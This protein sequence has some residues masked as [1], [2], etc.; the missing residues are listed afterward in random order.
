MYPSLNNDEL[1]YAYDCVGLVMSD[2]P[3]R[4]SSH[5]VSR[6]A[7]VLS[8]RRPGPK[9][10]LSSM[11]A[12]LFRRDAASSLALTQVTE[13]VGDSQ[14]VD[15][16]DT[17][18]GNQNFAAVVVYH[19]LGC[20]AN[21]PQLIT[22]RVVNL[23]VD[24]IAHGD[25]Y[26]RFYAS[27]ALC[28]MLDA[29]AEHSEHASRDIWARNIIADIIDTG[30]TLEAGW[31]IDSVALLVHK[32]HFALSTGVVR[33]VDHA[34]STPTAERVYGGVTIASADACSLLMYLCRR[35]HGCLN[36]VFADDYEIEGDA[37]VT[38]YLL[39]NSVVIVCK[40]LASCLHFPVYRAQAKE[41][42]ILTS[43]AAILSAEDAVDTPTEAENVLSLIQVATAAL[44]PLG[45]GDAFA[46]L[47]SKTEAA[48]E[49]ERLELEA[50]VAL[51]FFGI[52]SS[53]V[54]AS[55]DKALIFE[56]LRCL[57]HVSR[58]G[59]FRACCLGCL[60]SS[61]RGVSPI[62][63]C[64]KV[65]DD[66]SFNTSLDLV[67]ATMGLLAS[68]CNDKKFRFQLRGDA[69]LLKKIAAN[70][71]A[72]LH[73]AM[74]YTQG[75]ADLSMSFSDDDEDRECTDD[76]A[77][78]IGEYLKNTAVSVSGRHA[79]AE[80][81]LINASLI[82]L[83]APEDG[84]DDAA[85]PEPLGQSFFRRIMRRPDRRDLIRKGSD[86]KKCSSVFLAVA[87]LARVLAV[88]YSYLIDFARVN[89]YKPREST[90]VATSVE[91]RFLIDTFL[92]LLIEV[93]EYLRLYL[94]H[95]PALLRSR[96]FESLLGGILELC[97]LHIPLMPFL[98]AQTDIVLLRNKFRF[99]NKRRIP[100]L[101]ELEI[102]AL[103][104]IILSVYSPRSTALA[105]YG[106]NLMH[107]LDV[108]SVFSDTLVTASAVELALRHLL[109]NEDLTKT[110]AD[111]GMPADSADSAGLAAAGLDHSLEHSAGPGPV[112]RAGIADSKRATSGHR[113]DTVIEAAVFVS[114]MSVD[115]PD[116]ISPALVASLL[117]AW[118]V[119][120]RSAPEDNE[121]I[122]AAVGN[123]LRNVAPGKRGAVRALLRN[124]SIQALVTSIWG[125]HE[126]AKHEEKHADSVHV[127]M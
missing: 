14:F 32:M 101:N 3:K 4:V 126:S 68:F 104:L 100:A 118:Y 67:Q 106:C 9:S 69:V 71:R 74:S 7:D 28:R 124:K 95:N 86:L 12:S 81:R 20:E 63:F 64:R 92:P 21:Y 30:E 34:A 123:A 127:D 27:L 2:P 120:Y 13:P 61:E 102:R 98:S 82:G 54:H 18:N 57:A 1:F 78:K 52:L 5:V 56:S 42:R 117:N 122:F 38:P 70:C 76:E 22:S 33:Y 53:F 91:A 51:D 79:D 77:H 119:I 94:R 73:K 40:A 25:S 45:E 46:G 99:G 80:I 87:E 60:A 116:L 62:E 72:L 125:I 110:L 89:F 58:I 84:L 65:F 19:L 93:G 109:K 112:S 85:P 29:P 43:V 66:I 96:V 26:G 23:L 10:L 115:R 88:D 41:A 8:Y 31:Q 121:F 105:I 35:L 111:C 83:H 49:S 24:V 90:E 107:G 47:A 17:E 11:R 6:I 103:Q 59:T 44:T 108:S 50:L 16:F 15:G 37:P 114:K 48:R 113:T 36:D 75:N 55:T 97:Q 39:S